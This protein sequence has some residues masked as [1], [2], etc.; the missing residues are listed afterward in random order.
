MKPNATT[1]KKYLITTLMFLF[2]G[3]YAHAQQ[4]PKTKVVE[5]HTSA[6]CGECKAFIE[7]AAYGVKG[8]KRAEVDLDTKVATVTFKPK[9]TDEA[10][11]RK[12]ISMAGYDADDVARDQEAFDNLPKCCRTGI[13]E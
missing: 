3:A 5:I 7:E 2:L 4:A 11:I 1:M 12:A 6:L 13:E 10:A 9:K 8:V